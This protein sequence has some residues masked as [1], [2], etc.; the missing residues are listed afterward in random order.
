MNRT[1][2]VKDKNFWKVCQMAADSVGL[3]MSEM[4]RKGLMRELE[5]IMRENGPMPDKT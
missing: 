5:R 4:I 3:S 1:I 2:Y